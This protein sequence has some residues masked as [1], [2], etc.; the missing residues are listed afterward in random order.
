MP[1]NQE[2]LTI[3]AN[4]S[5]LV[6]QLK[7]AEAQEESQEPSAPMEEGGEMDL[8]KI[9]K[10]LKAMEDGEEDEN[11]EVEKSEN[12]PSPD[13]K[14][15][16]E[17]NLDEQPEENDKNV[18]EVAKALFAMMNKG[19]PAVKKSNP[20]DDVLKVVKSLADETVENRKALNSILE[21]LGVA[22]E[23]KKS[24]ELKKSQERVKN[25]P[26]DLK[27]SLDYIVEQLK[28]Q[29]SSTVATNDS[30]VLQKSLTADGGALLHGIFTGKK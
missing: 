20:L 1:N 30:H 18:K 13:D 9:K 12:S 3:L 4:I 19:K 10:Y 2:F 27:K 23:I 15:F 14:N 28:P 24:V 7:Q 17:Q 8:E 16:A 6:E 21:G 11:K 25:D 5:S 22:D 29:Q 26:T